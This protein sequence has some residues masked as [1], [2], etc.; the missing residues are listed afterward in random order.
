MC[1]LFLALQQH[2]KY[3]VIICANRDEFHQR[4]TQKM[5]QWDKTNILAGKDLQAGGTWLGLNSNGRF[6]ALTN[7]RQPATFNINKKSRGDLVLQALTN[8][9]D[10]MASTL[11][12]TYQH[13]NGF[14]LV[15]GALN[16][17]HCFDSINNRHHQL[18]SG[19]HSI[20]NGALDDLWPK[21]Q[22]GQQQLTAVITEH[23]SSSQQ[24]LNI[25]KLFKIMSNDTQSLPEYL[26]KTGVSDDWEQMLSSIFI[27]SEKY[28]TRSTVILTCDLDNNIEVHEQNYDKQ[29]QKI[30]KQHF[31][32]S[33]QFQRSE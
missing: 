26:P 30:N 8:T 16:N 33:E 32:L 15:Y 23:Q 7:F 13:Y 17:L 21:M 19:V 24:P 28:G 12:T 31:K 18:T 2:P 1:I 6:S 22:L 3:P 20:C 9:N 5:H 14:N 11:K 29:G 25:E 10:D 27:V 4:P